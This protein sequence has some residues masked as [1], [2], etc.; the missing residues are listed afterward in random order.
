VPVIPPPCGPAPTHRRALV[1]SQWGINPSTSTATFDPD[2]R[3]R[4]RPSTATAAPTLANPRSYQCRLKKRQA[5]DG[6]FKCEAL[7]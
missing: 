4:P 2:L 7:P 3:P 5:I 1:R 6:V